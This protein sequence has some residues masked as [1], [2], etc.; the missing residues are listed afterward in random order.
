MTIFNFKSEVDV[1]TSGLP[2][3]SSSRDDPNFLFHHAIPFFD[4]HPLFS[5]FGGFGFG[6]R[7]EPW[8]KG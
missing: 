1:I 2:S 7:K 4:N 6:R 8:W 5:T 3:T